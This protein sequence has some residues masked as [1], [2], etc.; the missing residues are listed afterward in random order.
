MGR[1]SHELKVAALLPSIVGCDGK[2]PFSSYRRATEVNK[3]HGRTKKGR[4]VYRCVHCGE[5]HLGNDPAKA[6]RLRAVQA[7]ERRDARHGEVDE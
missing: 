2:V 1:D 6:R 3:R 4:Q 7:Q 5:W